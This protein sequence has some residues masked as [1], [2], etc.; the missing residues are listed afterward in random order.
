MSILLHVGVQKKAKKYFSVL[1]LLVSLLHLKLLLYSGGDRVDISSSAV[2]MCTF[3][4]K[5]ACLLTFAWSRSAVCFPFV[6][7]LFFFFPRIISASSLFLYSKFASCGH[8]A[9]E[10]THGAI[11]EHACFHFPICHAPWC[12]AICPCTVTKL[13]A[14]ML[15]GHEKTN[16]SCFLHEWTKT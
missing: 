3:G 7:L 15:R 14:N 1:P 4:L 9:G 5:S 13:N 10:K 8:V 16:Q 12:S 6:L 2:G 11:S